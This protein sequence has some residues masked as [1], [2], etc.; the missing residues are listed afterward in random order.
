MRSRQKF[1]EVKNSKEDYHGS[2]NFEVFYN[3][4]QNKLLPN[5]PKKSCIVMDRATYHMVPEER[6]IPS[7]MKKDDIQKWLTKHNIYWDESW[8]KPHT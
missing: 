7:Q 1:F 5:L 4:F 3:W 8:L 6:L 2:F